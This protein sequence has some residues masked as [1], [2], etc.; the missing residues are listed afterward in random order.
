MRRGTSPAGA[1]AAPWA[2]QP[3]A[4]RLLPRMSVKDLRE[5]AKDKNAQEGVRTMALRMYQGKR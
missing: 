4:L 2:A 5:L 1:D 3:A